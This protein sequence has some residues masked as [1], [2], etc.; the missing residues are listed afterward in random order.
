MADNADDKQTSAKASAKADDDTALETMQKQIAQMRREI[1]SLKRSLADQAEEVVEDA[2]GWFDT[3]TEGASRAA[4][5][6]RSK[7]QTV[8]GAVQDNPVTI[9]TALVVG[10]II[11]LLAGMA[12]GT[13]ATPR[14][15]YDRR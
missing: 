14:P 7:A 12:L 6:L 15:W 5:S 1:S 9:S 2:E 3:A 11:G 8:S 13:S 4:Q 10:G